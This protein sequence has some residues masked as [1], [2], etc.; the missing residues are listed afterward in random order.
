MS[1][2]GRQGGCG[3]GGNKYI[4]MN[5]CRYTHTHTYIYSYIYIYM[6]I[7]VCVCVFV[8]V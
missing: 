6:Y 8:C 7:Y 3:E 1:E 4:Y 2:G 5:V